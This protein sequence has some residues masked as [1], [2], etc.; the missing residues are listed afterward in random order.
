MSI[1]CMT[2]G[3]S[4]L[5]KRSVRPVSRSNAWIPQSAGFAQN[6]SQSNGSRPSST[7]PS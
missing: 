4:F 3:M 5:E 6:V 2:S 7:A 1:I